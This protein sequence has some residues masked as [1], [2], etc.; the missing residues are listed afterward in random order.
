[1]KKRMVVFLSSIILLSACN[2]STISEDEYNSLEE[3]MTLSEV[4]DLV[5][6]NGKRANSNGYTDVTYDGDSEET[7]EIDFAVMVFEKGK[8]RVWDRVDNN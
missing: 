7:G 6:S 3:G 5:G 2:S 1:M 8:L 4:A